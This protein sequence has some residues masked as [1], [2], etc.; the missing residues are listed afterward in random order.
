MRSIEIAN[1]AVL[2]PTVVTLLE[3]DEPDE[4]NDVLILCQKI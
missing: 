3:N 4:V 1:T 2:K